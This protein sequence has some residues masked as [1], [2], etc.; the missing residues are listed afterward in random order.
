MPKV[1]VTGISGFLGSYLADKLI[2]E[3]HEVAGFIRQTNRL[4][5]PSVQHLVGRVAMYYG[6]LTDSTAVRWTLSDFQ[7]EYICHLGAVTPVAYSFDH[8]NEVV[9]TNFVGTL[10]LAEA[11][12]RNCHSLKKFLYASSMEVYGFQEVQEPF[13]ETHEPKPAC[14]Y[15]VSKLASEKYLQY[16]N[17]AFKFP[18]VA[19]R[20]TN[21]YG[22]REN[23]YFVVEA[24]ITQMLNSNTINVGD[25]RPYRNFIFIDDLTELYSQVISSDEPALL[26][27]VFNTGPSNALNIEALVSKIAGLLDWDGQIN[28]YTRPRRPGEIFYL[29]S[30]NDKISDLIGWKPQIDLADGIR[31]TIQIWRENL[32][33]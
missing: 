12:M 30:S 23:D 8:P 28:W 14:P 7:P 6:S 27:G 16:M 15:A 29:N 32:K 21:C 4:N 20:Q 25:P 19:F 11:A 24:I 2:A 3:G 10:N 31:R 9:E 17:Y 18:A 22:R 5:Y 1:F 33:K 13:V 26:G